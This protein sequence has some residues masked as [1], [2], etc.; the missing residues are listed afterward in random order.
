MKIPGEINFNNE[1]DRKQLNSLQI[2]Q[3]EFSN[4]NSVETIN[5]LEIIPEIQ[6]NKN[7]IRKMLGDMD[8]DFDK[9]ICLASTDVNQFIFNLGLYMALNNKNIRF[10]SEHEMYYIGK[11]RRN[12]D[13]LDDHFTLM[14]ENIYYDDEDEDYE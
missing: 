5:N 12:Q 3:I 11:L 10:K 4:P 1:F 14:D 6:F 7:L 8:I 9:P 2:V 13:L